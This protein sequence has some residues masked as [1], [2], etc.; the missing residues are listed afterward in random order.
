M[1]A[2][3]LLMADVVDLIEKRLDTTRPATPLV[4]KDGVVSQE[5][6][7]GARAVKYQFASA[8]PDGGRS[9]RGIRNMLFNNM[10]RLA[11]R[12]TRI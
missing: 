2:I 5:W 8:M 1:A 9:M 3:L 10:L 12:A 7:M 6:A 11:D 4:G